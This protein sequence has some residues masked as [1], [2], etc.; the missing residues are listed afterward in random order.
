M[1][2]RSVRL[3]QRSMPST[4]WLMPSDQ[5]WQANEVLIV[6]PTRNYTVND[7]RD[8]FYDL[9][10][11]DGYSMRLDTV[12]LIRNLT[13]PGI[14]IHCLHGNETQTPDQL[15]FSAKQWPDMQPNVVFGDGD[16]TVNIRSL[17]GCLHWIGK[18]KQKILHKVF[19]HTDHMN[20]LKQQGVF[21]YIKYVVY[22]T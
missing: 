22:N 4:S 13:P 6:S 16:G 3:E 17:H 15:I 7:Y 21:D 8:L 18:Q 12:N 20:I 19:P 11:P 5:F 2:P 9:G 14:E 10:F 1:N